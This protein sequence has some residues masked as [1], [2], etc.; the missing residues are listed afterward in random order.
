MKV[1]PHQARYCAEELLCRRADEA[2]G[3]LSHSLL[4]TRV[5][6]NPHQIDAALFALQNP[7]Q[8]GV[9]LADEVGLGKTIEAG[10]VLCQLWAERKRRLLVVC[11]A[12]LRKQWAQE[13]ADKFALPALIVDATVL[14]KS[15]LSAAAFLRAQAGQAVVVVS[16]PFAV[17]HE[18]AFLAEA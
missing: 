3:R 4:D 5:E 11:P 14:R 10:L 18:E 6:L 15:G 17:K 8:Q 1:T 9:L 12:S 16:Y 7:L 13:M 2:L